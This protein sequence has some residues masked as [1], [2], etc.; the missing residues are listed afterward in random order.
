MSTISSL[1]ARQILD[2]RGNPTVEVDCTVDD[3]SF[4]RA[5][6]P[7]GAST[8]AHEAL[9]LRDDGKEYGGKS[10]M[11]AIENVN[12][13][14][15]KELNGKSVS[16]QRTLDQLLLDLDGT[17]NKSKLG[18]N[19]ILGVS[20]AVCRARAASEKQSLWQ[21][22]ASQYDVSDAHHLPVPMMNVL[23]GGAH[24]NPCFSGTTVRAW[25]EVLDKAETSAPGVGAVRLRLVATSAGGS[26][27]LKGE[28]GKY[29]S[30]VLLDLDYWALMPV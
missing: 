9:E 3:G 13:P 8:G 30:H 16:D 26:M 20:M 18:A 21:S 22:L 17:E 5:A 15:A 7:S 29:L 4:G 14:I 1:K 2:S 25:S 23:N 28:D 27:E 12:G 10:V 6:V 24:A 19:A 11:K